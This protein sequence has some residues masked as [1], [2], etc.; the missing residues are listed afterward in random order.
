MKWKACM[1]DSGYGAMSR[2][3]LESLVRRYGE[4]NIE[5]ALK[6]YPTPEEIIA[7]CQEADAILGCGNPPITREVLYGLPNLKVVQRYGIGVNS[8]DL[9]AA[10]ECGVVVLNLPG[11]CVEELAVHATALALDVLRHI[12]YYDRGIRQG[13]WRKAKGVPP[14]NPAE[15]TVGLH[16]FGGSAKPMYRIFHDG[17]LAKV[18]A[19]DPFLTAEDVKDY[20]VELVSFDELLARSDILSIHAPLNSHTRHIFN[21]GTFQKMKPDSAIINI[22]RGP[23]ICQEDLIRALQEGEIAFAGLD[24][25]E[26]EPLPADSPLISMDNVVLTCHSA[27]YGVN[28]KAAVRRLVV[29][30]MDQLVNRNCIPRRYIANVGVQPKLSTLKILD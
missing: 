24:V 12:T 6:H 16:G 21:Y 11:F 4:A 28:S 26:E 27:F 29:E 1:V 22:A 23:L 8:V 9:D 25:F 30:L 17:F 5:V 10:R 20:D 18:I 19:C 3:E 13:E 14:R 15:M 7:N 2:E